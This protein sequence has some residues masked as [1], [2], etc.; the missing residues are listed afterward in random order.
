MGYVLLMK[1]CPNCQNTE[2]DDA[3]FCTKCGVNLPDYQQ[4]GENTNIF[5]GQQTNVPNPNQQPPPPM[6]P[7]FQ[8]PPPPMNP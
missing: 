8:Q 7:Y 3:K 2:K 4:K 5:S 1:T 6:N